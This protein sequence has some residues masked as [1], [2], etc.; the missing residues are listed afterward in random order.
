METI[1]KVPL[2]AG[3]DEIG[4]GSGI[5]L[6]RFRAVGTAIFQSSAQLFLPQTKKYF[7][8]TTAREEQRS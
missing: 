6:I 4:F 3:F 2:C 7:P 1:Y 5:E 8:N